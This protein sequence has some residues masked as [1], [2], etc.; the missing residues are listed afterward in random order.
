MPP[1]FLRSIAHLTF[2]RC[3]RTQHL[4]AM[5]KDE[6]VGVHFSRSELVDVTPNPFFARF[7][8]AHEWM[9]GLLEVLRG[10]FVFGRIA[11][12]D[13]TALQTHAEMYPCVT[14]LYAVLADI[15]I[16]ASELDLIEMSAVIAHTNLRCETVMQ[17]SPQSVFLRPCDPTS[18]A[19][20]LLHRSIDRNRADLRSATRKSADRRT[21]E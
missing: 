19:L 2:S 12:A 9:I 6:A 11:A 16:G 18:R 4:L 7:R 14:R 1:F 21:S 17:K 20:I 15:L 10:V 13:V 3:S 8:G 5:N